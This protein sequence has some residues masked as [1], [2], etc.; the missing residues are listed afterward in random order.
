MAIVSQT[1]GW[2]EWT[3]WGLF[4]G[5][6]V[7]AGYLLCKAALLHYSTLAQPSDRMRTLAVIA[8][9]L[10]VPC[11]SFLPNCGPLCMLSGGARPVCAL[12][13]SLK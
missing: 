7:V 6:D 11:L 2:G 8:A 13:F 9:A 1:L 10:Y 12:T 4:G 5:A 3:S